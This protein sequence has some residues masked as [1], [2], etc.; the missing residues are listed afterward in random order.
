MQLYWCD[1]KLAISEII[2]AVKC[3]WDFLETFIAGSSWFLRSFLWARS[4]LVDKYPDLSECFVKGLLFKCEIYFPGLYVW[5][6]WVMVLESCGTF[7]R[8]S[9]ARKE[10]L[11]QVS[12]VHNPAGFL[13]TLSFLFGDTMWAVSTH[14]PSPIPALN[15]L[16]IF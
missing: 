7:L 14:P 16:S 13:F 15:R 6:R 1:P 9:T 11:E 12:R 5:T 10:T 3:Y 4:M 8:W 2:L